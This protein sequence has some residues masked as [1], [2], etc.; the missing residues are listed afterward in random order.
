V[1]SHE[2]EPQS[3]CLDSNSLSVF[4]GA[5]LEVTP[6]NEEKPSPLSFSRAYSL[7]LAPQII[8]T[9]SQ[10]LKILVSSKVYRQVDFLAMG[11]WWI[12]TANKS[13]SKS[14][15]SDEL[16]SSSQ[17]GR[18]IRVPTSREDVAFADSSIDLRSKRLVMKVLR[19][20]MDYKEQSELWEDYREKPFAEFLAQRFKLTPLLMDLFVGLTLST[21]SPDSLTT[22]FA[23]PRLAR[24][25]T[26]LGR[27]GSSFS[28]VIPKWGGLSE[29]A[30]VSCR[31]GAVGG[32]VY[33]LGTGITQ[34]KQA[35]EGKGSE[36]TER[37]VQ[38]S[39]GDVVKS[40]VVVGST[41][42]SSSGI[43]KQRRQISSTARISHLITIVSSSLTGL[44]T[45]TSEG[46]PTPAG[47]VVIFPAGSL[48][49]STNPVYLFI[50]SSDT[51]ECPKGQ[52]KYRILASTILVI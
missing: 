29:I 47:S 13:P 23:L 11:S 42:T 16:E 37:I 3:D 33:M 21:S 44:F 31:A 1:K 34:I 9:D 35:D 39:N 36:N 32:A 43:Q 52:C 12:Y 40:K 28:S 25:L 38:L 51:G 20:L 4:G 6:F 8:Y 19:F 2:F 27:L 18:L 30:Q 14:T 5:K 26:S 48:D 50:H 24:H 49:S 17:E 22:D 10:L 15:E 45:N 7:A 41:E 46:D